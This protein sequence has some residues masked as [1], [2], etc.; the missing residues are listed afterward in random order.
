M[1]FSSRP[2]VRS[3]VIPGLALLLAGG[4]ASGP[5][6]NG[7][8]PQ[9]PTG[10]STALVGALDRIGAAATGATV[11]LAAGNPLGERRVRVLHE[12]RAASGRLCRRVARSDGSATSVICRRADGHWSATRGLGGGDAAIR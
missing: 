10:D 3:L 1:A 4:C 9:A 11:D 12:Y 2:G 5:P 8:V 6:G 7:A